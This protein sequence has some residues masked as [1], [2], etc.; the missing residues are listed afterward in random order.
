MPRTPYNP[1]LRRPVHI[2]GV[3]WVGLQTLYLKEVRRFMNVPTQTLLGPVVT[4]VLFMMVFAVAVGERA[5]LGAGNSFVQ[6]LAPGLVMMTVLQNAF[7]NSSSSLV[8]SKVQGN[9]VDLLMPP[10]GP[11]ELLVGLAVGGMTRGIAVGLVAALV[12]GIFGGLSLP[13]APL[14]A[15]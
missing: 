1:S 14:T 8:V 5:G 11:G 2:S 15:R 6:F 4:A 7:A 12:L 3:N 13:A 10:I 9:I